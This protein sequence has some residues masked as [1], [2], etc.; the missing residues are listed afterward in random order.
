MEGLMEFTGERVVPGQT[1]PDLMNEH[2]ARYAFAERLVGSKRVLDAG[3]GIAYGASFL[4]RSAD[5]VFA[6]D[7]SL[8]PLLEGRA[9]YAG[10]NIGYLQGDCT[11]LPLADGSVDV[12]VAFEVIEHLDNW[13]GLLA[14]ARRVLAPAGQLV[15]STPNR[16]YYGETRDTPNVFHVHEFAFEEFRAELSQVFAHTAIFLQNHTDAIAFTPTDTQGVRVR[17]EPGE[18]RPAEAHFFVAVCSQ[19]PL[20]GSP[21]FVYVPRTGNVLRDREQHID[22]LEAELQQKSRWLA[23]TA[24]ELEKLSRINKAEQE[25]A[26]QAIDELGQENERK[27]KWAADLEAKLDERTKWS[28]QLEAENKEVVANFQ[29]LEEEHQKVQAELKKCVELLDRAEQTVIERTEWAQRLTRD[30]EALYASPAYRF[31]RRLGLAPNP[32]AEAGNSTPGSRKS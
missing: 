7:N 12:V 5:R 2:L 25:K 14:E 9:K 15:V 24:A 18:A 31:G 20:Y 10:A 26:Q 27:T 19:Q 13:R 21:A 22:L 16:L 30:L 17:L 23:E 1:D 4:A 28:V 32:P 8:E 6:L 3:C 11:R 29:R